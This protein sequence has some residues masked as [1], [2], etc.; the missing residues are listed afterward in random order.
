MTKRLLFLAFWA[1]VAVG[2]WWWGNRPVPLAMSF[3]Q[4]FPSVSFA[5]YRFGESPIDHDYPTPEEIDSDL[6]SLK[7]VAQGIRT[8]TAREGMD[9]VPE[10]AAKYGLDVIHSAWLGPHKDKNDLDVAALIS[11]ANAHPDAIKRVIVGNEVLL[12]K[13]LPVDQLIAYI[14][15]VK[16]AVK[17][18]VSYADVWAF[19]LKY[20]EVA[21]EVDF[22][23]IHI[24]PY[25]EDE[26][27]GV[28]DAA[29]H[30]VETYRI[31]QNAFP[32]KPILIGES[33]W[34]TRGRQRGPASASVEDA[35]RYVRALAL[36]AKQNGFDYNLVEAFDQPWK[37]V[38]EGTVG[39]NWG[40]VDSHRRVKYGMSGPV[41]ENRD[42]QWQCGLS[43]LLGLAAGLWATAKAGRGALPLA[44]FAQ[45]L[46]GMFVWQA[47]N[48]W[49]IAYDW[50]G[51]AWALFRIGL[52]AW[53]AAILTAAATEHFGGPKPDGKQSRWGERLVVIYAAS[54]VLDTLILVVAGRY[55]DIPNLEFLIPAL[56]VIA[57]C[58]L[59]L[60][61]GLARALAVGGLF[62]EREAGHGFDLARTFTLWLWA[63][64]A[65]APLS[66]A[67]ALSRGTDFIHAH[68]TFATQLPLLLASLT[69]NR[70]MLIWSG[71]LIVLSLP[72]AAE[73]L[74]TRAIPVS[75]ASLEP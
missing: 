51:I 74:V 63:S 33:G 38:L 75:P 11:S 71:M 34:P 13:D 19:W 18:P 55:R 20:P 57:F 41:Q 66:E 25:W 59:R 73:W 46:A 32:G 64:A 2:V 58:L 69:D 54:A 52:Q 53:L 28:E 1:S 68:P 10:M 14:R 67:L 62:V 49:T 3:E 72:F 61:L 30:L 48:A 45:L 26:P 65:L 24:L 17:Q 6:A 5:P 23:T 70:Q 43:V 27:V 37:A 21:N 50:P 35:A 44:G 36:V 56:G 16:A 12:R 60:R 31:I 9:V 22:I 29:K 8:Y 7:G 39:A 47:L 15:K 4:P 42:W 40:V